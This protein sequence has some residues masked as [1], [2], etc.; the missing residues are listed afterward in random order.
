LVAEGGLVRWR[1]RDLLQGLRASKPLD[2]LARLGLVGR[3]VFYLLLAVLAIALVI[4]GDAKRQA[5]ANGALSAVADTV[6]GEVLLL[7][8][9][10][11]FVAFGLLRI[12]G[13]AADHGP[14]RLRRLSTAGQGV[15]H[16]GLAAAT[17]AF[18]LGQ[19]GVGSEAEQ[20]HTASTVLSLPGGRV[21]LGGVGLV[22]LAT[23]LWQLVVTVSGG[24]ADTLHLSGADHS[25]RKLTLLTA[26]IG[27]PARALAVAP[28]G[29]FLLVAAVHDQ[30]AQA[31]G[32]DGFLLELTDSRWGTVLAVLVAVGFV[33]FALY[34]FLEARFRQVS[35][36]S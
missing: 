32:L 19:H 29:A 6:I 23:C 4:S 22:V 2:A 25:V 7:A 3:G 16:L 27:I 36:G 21:L 31:K 30:P 33:V 1:F 28:I 20:R 18:L 12:V 11:G 35:A 15:V 17:A 10:F 14:G 13:A 34:S 8:A 24:F 26:R 9:V 5:N